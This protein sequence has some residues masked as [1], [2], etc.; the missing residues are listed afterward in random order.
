MK[1][2]AKY[3]N[4]FKFIFFYNFVYNKC[5]NSYSYFNK[6]YA[7]NNRLYPQPPKKIR[8]QQTHYYNE[9]LQSKSF[10]FKSKLFKKPCEHD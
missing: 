2:A 7:R 6:Q 3:F 9:Q 8:Q 10:Y 4:D 5:Y 1:S